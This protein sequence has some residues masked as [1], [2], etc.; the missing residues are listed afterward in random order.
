MA[1]RSLMVAAAMDEQI[2]VHVFRHGHAYVALNLIR[3]RRRFIARS[4]AL[5]HDWL[6]SPMSSSTVFPRCGGFWQT[7]CC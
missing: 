7:P 2:E 5:L 1:P 4:G 6:A 3:R